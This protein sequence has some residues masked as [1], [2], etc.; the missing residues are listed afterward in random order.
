M[1]GNNFLS[2]RIEE[3]MRT[4]YPRS[5]S[6]WEPEEISALQ[7][8]FE[9]FQQ[10]GVRSLKTKFIQ[11]YAE[12]IQ[13]NP[14]SVQAKL[15]ELYSE[16]DEYYKNK[17]TKAAAKK[18]ILKDVE[19]D[20]PTASFA[21]NPEALEILDALENT[22][23]NI[24]VTGQ[25]GTGK[26]TL[27][28][29]F[30]SE[31]AKQIVVLAPTGVA[32]VNIRG[33]TIH[34]FCN[35]PAGITQDQVKVL[36]P[37]NERRALLENLNTIVID[38]ISMVRADLLDCVDK[39]LRLNG[40]QPDQPFGGY[41]MVFI[42]DLYQLSPVDK[43]FVQAGALIQAYQSPYFF[44]ANSFSQADWKFFELSQIYR[45]QDQEFIEVLNAIR[46]KDV[47][48]AHYNLLNNQIVDEEESI[49][50]Q[51]F[52]VYLTATNARATDINMYFLRKLPSEAKSYNGILTGK[53]SESALPAER[54]I[55]IKVGAQVMLVNNDRSARWVNGTMGTVKR[56]ITDKEGGPDALHVELETG[57]EEY[58]RPHTWEMTEYTHDKIENRIRN[59]VIGSYTQ[60]PVRLAWALTIHKSQGKTF[61]KVFI[62][63]S[64]GMF[65]H[66]QLYVALSRC[67]TLEG[68]MLNH[69]VRPEHILLDDRV[70]TFLTNLK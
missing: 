51:D 40:K 8:A 68:I 41:Q 56:I 67:R 45:Q 60:Y 5:F 24:F 6:P 1:T 15:M 47:T 34:S 55:S 64:R 4:K 13:R 57:D 27:L 54:S 17:Q 33:Q 70:I 59:K 53:F 49:V 38:E 7:Q 48:A 25:A 12:K 18:Q 28:N 9:S 39:Y 37:S 19:T 26:S 66:G 69:P 11:P 30:R 35:F 23:T 29:Y 43:D 3:I 52:G 2:R 36:A 21:E 50:S 65:A 22:D 20:R 44:H 32:A 14:K 58:I 10:S 42:G 62:D 46:N 61:D 31:T 63:L 16:L